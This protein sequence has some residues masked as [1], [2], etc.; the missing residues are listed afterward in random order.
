MDA[1]RSVVASTFL[2]VATAL[3]VPLTGAYADDPK[4]PL[5]ATAPDS[6]TAPT[7][8]QDDVAAAAADRIVGARVPQLHLSRHDEVHAQRTL[9]SGPLR[10]VPYERT[11]RGLPVVGG[12]FVVVV[13]GDGNVVFT[14]VAQTA[15]VS[16]PDVKASVPATT[17][18]SKAAGKVADARLGRSRLVVLQ[19]G[20]RSDLAWQTT[21][22]GRRAGKPS[23][24]DVYV[25]ADSGELLRTEENVLYGD[26][27]AGWSGPNPVPIQTRKVGAVFEM[28]MKTAP[29]MTCQDLANGQTFTGPD[30]VWGNGNPVNKETGCVDAMYA[31][32]QMNKMMASW[33][34]R[35]GMNGSNGWLP[36]RVGLNELNAFYDGTQV[37]IGRNTAFQWISALDIVAHEFGHGVDHHT[38]GGISGGNTQEFIGDAYGASTEWFDNQ[39][40]PFDQR[41]FLVGEE[42]SL[43]GSGEIR[44]MSDPGAEGDPN[45]YS[46]AVGDP[47]LTEVHAAAGPGNHWFYIASQ[48]TNPTG[49]PTSPTCNGSTQ[50]GIGIQKVMKVLYTAMLMKNS[51]SSYPNYRL[52]TL[53]AARHL[54]GQSSCTEFNRV[55][56]AWNAVSVPPQPGEPT[57]T[58]NAGAVTITNATERIAT[59]GTKPAAF[60]MTATGGTAPYTWTATG[61]PPGMSINASTGRVAGTPSKAAAGT[62]GVH[63][64]AT[65]NVGAIG[66]AWFT[67]RVD[68]ATA[69]AC[70]GQR[71]GNSDFELPTD[72]PWTAFSGLIGPYGEP[73]SRS[74]VKHAWL[75]GY[76][77]STNHLGTR[78]DT[79]TQRVTFPAG[80]KAR[81]VFYVWS[82]TDEAPTAVFDTM[83]VKAGGTTLL[84]RSNLDACSGCPK[85]YVKVTKALPS[86]L[87]GK[88]FDL[89]FI[90]AEDSSFFTN[91]HV[92]DVTLKISAP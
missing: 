84:T 78:V 72:A 60:T 15:K 3:T 16:L 7:G 54:F 92:D 85:N 79:L 42:V 38:P 39:P 43:N 19:R 91:W 81:L 26:G 63:V 89:A 49:G 6:D 57:C 20:S 33:L 17:A 34:G 28:T 23:R 37:Q 59:A 75:G 80:C 30:D 14:S 90:T 29:T 44:N 64:L 13:D 12:D 48:G 24:L 83:T 56:A 31:A 46:A 77:G 45:C 8:S 82:L 25:D 32:Q 21:A 53:I 47:T 50:K 74:G 41:D 52:W 58:K 66:E 4:P 2:A 62:H 76:G 68:A 55:R 86:S 18:R 69:T 65:D 67:Y 51:A 73:L 70:T 40:A 1:T 71:L 27:N 36:I 9:R 5:P 87:A 22:T 11:Y 35:S 61:L 88:T 10:F